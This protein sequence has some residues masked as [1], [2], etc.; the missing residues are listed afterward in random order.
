MNK[1]GPSSKANA[2]TAET[3]SSFHTE[4]QSAALRATRTSASLPPD[5]AFYKTVDEDLKTSVDGLEA[6]VLA[7]IGRCLGLAGG[8]GKGREVRVDGEDVVDDFH[9]TIVDSVD[10]LLEKTD[11]CLDE[12]S[13]KLKR[14][15]APAKPAAPASAKKSTDAKPYLP[16]SLQHAPNIPKPQLAF[17]TQVD[18]SDDVPPPHIRFLKHKY[19]ARVP[20]GYVLQKEDVVDSFTDDESLLSSH[21]Y[22]YEITHLQHAPHVHNVPSSPDAPQSLPSPVTYVS[23]PTQFDA[24]LA[25]LTSPEVLEIAVDLEHHSYRTYRGFLC[26]MQLT[27]RTGG[28]FIVDLLVPSIRSRIHEL[29][30]AFTNPSKIKVFHGADS[31]IVWLQQDFGVYVVGLFDT[32]HASKLL[33]LP[34]HSLSTLLELYADYTPDKRYQLADWRIRPLGEEMLLYAQSDTHWLLYLYDRLRGA[35]VDKEKSSRPASRAGSP[36]DSTNGSRTLLDETLFRSAQTSLRQHTPEVYDAQRG[37]GPGGWDSL[38]KKWNKVALTYVPGDSSPSSS[39]SPPFEGVYRSQRTVYRA[40]HRWRD[41]VSR[42]ED[43]STRYV[44]PNH[45]LFTLAENP[46]ADMSALLGSFRGGAGVPAVVKKRAKELLEV[47]KEAVREG[48]QGA[49]QSAEVS[50]AKDEEKMVVDNKVEV[51]EVKTRSGGDGSGSLWG[52][53]S[54]STSL[55]AVSS[56]LLGAAS[57]S[58]SKSATTPSILSISTSALFGS[59]LSSNSVPSSSLFVGKP[60]DNPTFKALVSKINSTLVIVPSVPK[61]ASSSA[62]TVA[63]ATSS[64]SSE[65]IPTNTT[66]AEAEKIEEE[67]EVDQALGMQIDSKPMAFVPASQRIP[68]M[69]D[70]GPIVM[71]GR[72]SGG[73][74]SGAANRKKRKREAA[75][76]AAS[77]SAS[78]RESP[79]AEDNRGDG[80][81]ST[82]EPVIESSTTKNDIKPDTREADDDGP[83]EPYDFTATPNVLDQGPA[84]KK[85]K[86]NGSK[87]KDDAKKKG[88]GGTGS[89]YNP[90]FGAAPKQK[91]DYKGGNKSSTFK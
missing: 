50:K 40:V 25:H 32:F 66:E 83:D 56:T 81:P 87:K 88:K 71:V 20:L 18:N 78:A 31:D 82:E 38:A 21:P 13:G 55:V 48:L 41:R 68:G 39:S 19:N 10:V 57:S 17:P 52:T 62:A 46:P 72:K 2:P 6:R 49:I 1:A 77:A 59:V 64:K 27:T 14:P 37:S 67:V 7:L 53:A 12:F 11:I 80:G 58:S 35:L 34:R 45:F 9:S 3:F 75:S 15:A 51:V 44:L 8:K 79:S 16:A 91:S 43:E 29:N 74:G 22:Y 89:F 85:V 61:A 26:L 65:P 4:L 84:K 70:M 69:E 54:P 73:G 42:E 5:L 63:T 30:E 90:E 23:T 33:E 36:T 24:L 47:I 60:S 76:A 28:D 86:S